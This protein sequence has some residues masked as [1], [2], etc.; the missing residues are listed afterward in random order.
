MIRPRE[1]RFL[2]AAAVRVYAFATF[3]RVV[4]SARAWNYLDGAGARLG[5]THLV[6]V[7]VRQIRLG[8][9]VYSHARV[10]AP[11]RRY[12]RDWPLFSHDRREYL[13]RV[14]APAPLVWFCVVDSHGGFVPLVRRFC[15][16]WRNRRGKA[17]ELAAFRRER[18]KSILGRADDGDFRLRVVDAEAHLFAH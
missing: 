14:C 11:I 16:C 3:P 7:L 5:R 12:V 6:A 15:L 4:G 13:A 18:P 17:R 2:A 10:S 1:A 9:S 8:V